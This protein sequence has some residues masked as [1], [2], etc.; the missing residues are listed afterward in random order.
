MRYSELKEA[1]Y[2]PKDVPGLNIENA[3][4]N[5]FTKLN[6]IIDKKCQPWISASGGL[7]LRSVIYRG[8][9][10]PPSALFTR[11][12]RSDRK[13]KDT[14][15]EFHQFFNHIIQ[16]KGLTAN[17]SNSLFVN[18]NYEEARGYGAPFMIFPIG[19]FEFT[20]HPDYEDWTNDLADE[21]LEYLQKQE[22]QIIKRLKGNDKSLKAAIRSGN[23]I[24]IKSKS[25]LFI[26]YE[27]LE[28]LIQNK[29]GQKVKVDP[30]LIIMIFGKD[31]IRRWDDY[32]DY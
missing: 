29:K 31:T 32:Y 18:G 25:A 20:W 4:N 19:N 26:Y 5:V 11:A 28:P 10:E 7:T 9:D 15:L 22:P 21:D 23:E 30:R 14:S 27:F 12:I 13:A 6:S 8:T 24:M 17:R 2:D 16:A 3:V 1:K